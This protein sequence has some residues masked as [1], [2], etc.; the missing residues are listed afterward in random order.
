[1]NTEGSVVGEGGCRDSEGGRRRV[2]GDRLFERVLIVEGFFLAQRRKA[3]KRSGVSPT[4]AVTRRGCWASRSDANGL[5]VA[6]N[7]A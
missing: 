1:M 4:I 6:D 3:A 5:D 7:R 2:A